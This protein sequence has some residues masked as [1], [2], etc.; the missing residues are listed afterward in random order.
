MKKTAS[1]SLII[2]LILFFLNAVKASNVVELTPDNFDLLIG[3]DAPALVE[4]YAPWCGHCKKLAPIYEQLAD[5][6]SYAKDHVI[7]AKVDADKHRDLGTRFGVEGF[8]TLKWFQ[9][10]SSDK[11]D[12]YESSRELDSLV[13]FVEEKSGYKAKKPVTAVT[14]LTS[15]NFDDIALDPNKN[16]LSLLILLLS[17]IAPIYEKV[18]LDF[19]QESNCIVA[20][21]E[22]PSYKAIA[23]RYDVKGFPTIKFFQKGDDKTPI[24]YQG[25]RTEED[26]VKF[27]NKHCGTHRLI[28]G[29]LSEEK[30]T[31]ASTDEKSQIIIDAKS[32]ENKIDSRYSKYYIKVMEKINEKPNY[33]DNEI[34][35]LNNIIKTGK[36]S[37]GKLDDFTIRK[38]ILSSFKKDNDATNE[39]HVEL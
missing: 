21:L 15:H 30:F 37:G 35:R 23:E 25:D 19:E 1:S 32:I 5:A 24:D 29:G 13:T 9:K 39:P 27:L 16:V 33:V 34:D 11:P 10:G 31:S 18:A 8:P 28:G 26:F 14:E 7:I 17:S 20:N 2:F 38:N 4:F 36:M 12:D 3:K 22:A 6:F